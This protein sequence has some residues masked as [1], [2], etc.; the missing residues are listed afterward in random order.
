M[1]SAVSGVVGGCGEHVGRGRWK[2]TSLGIFYFFSVFFLIFPRVFHFW[3][4][5]GKKMS[6]RS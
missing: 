2:A 4:E 1:I 3:F 6:W 5:V